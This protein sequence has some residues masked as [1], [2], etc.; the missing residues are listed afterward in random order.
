[1]VPVLFF[2]LLLDVIFLGHNQNDPSEPEDEAKPTTCHAGLNQGVGSIGFI[3]NMEK[4]ESG[5][6]EKYSFRF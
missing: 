4:A 1:M 5:L 2:L 6:V 3:L